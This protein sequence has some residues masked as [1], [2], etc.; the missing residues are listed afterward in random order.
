[1]KDSK[2]P[3]DGKYHAALIS[4]IVLCLWSVALNA[5]PKE[6]PDTFGT[7]TT[8]KPE[9]TSPKKTTQTKPQPKKTFTLW[10]QAFDIK[11]P[12]VQSYI[13]HFSNEGKNTLSIW[14]R[15]MAL[16]EPIMRK[17]LRKH[18]VPEDLIYVAMI[19][20]GFV[21]TAQSPKHAIGF[22]QFMDETAREYGMRITPHVDERQDYIHATVAAAKYLKKLHTKFGSWTLAVAA[23]NAG[24]NRIERAIKKHNTNDFWRII[25]NNGLYDE[26]KHYVPKIV[27]AAYML[28]HA[29]TYNLHGVVKP[30]SLQPIKVNIAQ[31]LLLARVARV[32]KIKLSMMQLYN[33]E[34]KQHATP[35][36]SPHYTLRIP[37]TCAQAFLQQVDKINHKSTAPLL[38]HT[39][40]FGER[41]EDIAR[42]HQIAP[43]VIRFSNG[44]DE[45]EHPKLG[46]KLT[47]WPK[48]KGRWKPHPRRIKATIANLPFQYKDHERRFY[49]VRQGDTLKMIAKHFNLKVGDLLMWNDLEAKAHLLEG[50]VLQCYF[51]KTKRPTSLALL[52]AKHFR[53]S[54]RKDNRH[55]LPPVAIPTT[56]GTVHIIAQGDSLWSI[57]R[58]YQIDVET[59]KQWNPQLKATTLQIG[60]KIYIRKSK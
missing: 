45:D 49:I 29:K 10:G 28:K 2:S 34:L 8:T 4:A 41:V 32:C 15:R 46:Q 3:M 48:S 59:L 33:P 57:A 22:W 18:G 27:A 50:M 58:K 53:L 43:H 21:P 60:Q 26:T 37:K 12:W 7:K 35:P 13:T 16:Y 56:N 11:Q 5:A 40:A 1:M 19:E 54:A 55:K 38:T 30:P 36:K 20:S 24:P 23:F 47:L 44:L 9:P 52:P 25:A 14:I 39:V 31:P 42:H 6:V 17:V 51:P